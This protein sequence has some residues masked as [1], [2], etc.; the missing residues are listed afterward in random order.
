MFQ[1][2]H[3][4]LLIPAFDWQGHRGA[5]GLAPE[6][7]IPGFLRALE[8]PAITTLEL[9]VVVSA[10][11]QIVVSHEPWISPAICQCPEGGERINIYGLSYEE[12]RQYD[13]GLKKNPRF[14]EQQQFAAYKP[15]L[16]EVVRD[17]DDYCRKI[18]R[19]LPRVNIELTAK[20]EWDHIYTPAPGDFAK[21][22]WEEL[23]SLGIRERS[24]LQ[25][26]DDRILQELYRLDPGLTLSCLVEFPFDPE[27][28]V[29]E[30]GFSPA[31][32]SPY[33]RL[34]NRDLI[35][36]IHKK[37]M[38]VVPWTVNRTAAM[39]KLRKWGV[40]GVITDYPDR[41]PLES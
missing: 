33:Y 34:L 14:P 1:I 23:R 10:D 13:C 9:D 31:V 37:G 41:I 18:G 22:V 32:I 28:L 24:C 35:K 4:L 5:R 26:F 2:T 36:T 8:F 6:N 30:L 39:A 19:P 16:V 29:A 21:F 11:R 20:P 27:K 25:S 17:A 40:D 38:K 7:T 3:L 12:I 15:A